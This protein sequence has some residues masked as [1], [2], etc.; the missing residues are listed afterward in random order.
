LTWIGNPEILVGFLKLPAGS[1]EL[2]ENV[3]LTEFICEAR[4]I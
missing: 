4:S 1:V 2:L 3:Y